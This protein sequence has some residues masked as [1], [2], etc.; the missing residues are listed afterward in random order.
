MLELAK[1]AQRSRLGASR[2]GRSW[3]RKGKSR[4]LRIVQYTE[5]GKPEQER[6]SCQIFV[7]A[8]GLETIRTYVAKANC[9]S[10]P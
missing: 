9:C 8:Q 3:A 2:N 6:V 4:E 1:V 7:Q 10:N 5:L